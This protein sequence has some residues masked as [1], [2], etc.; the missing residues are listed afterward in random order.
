MTKKLLGI[1]L[2]LSLGLF[3]FAPV[4]VLVLHKGSPK[5][6]NSNALAGHMSH[7]DTVVPPQSGGG[8]TSN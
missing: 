7:G 2:I 3:S 4:R 8:E 6:I 5:W 1:M